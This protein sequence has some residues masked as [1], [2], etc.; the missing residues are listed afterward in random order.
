M[1]VVGRALALAGK[2]EPHGTAPR[3]FAPLVPAARGSATIGGEGCL[4][5]NRRG[6]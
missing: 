1:P 5:A 6:R 2:D 4:S 3:D